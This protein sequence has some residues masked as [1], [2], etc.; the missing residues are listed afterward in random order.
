MQAD[1]DRVAA[2]LADDRGMN[3][4]SPISSG[5]VAWSVLT[6]VRAGFG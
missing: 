5:T 1:L 6:T 4:K 3:Y 2:A